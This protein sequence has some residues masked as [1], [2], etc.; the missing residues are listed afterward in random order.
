VGP[1]HFED[2]QLRI[3]R[4]VVG[5]LENNV[6]VVVCAGTGQ[7]VVIDAAAE[8]NVISAALADVEP[9]AILTTH[10]HRDHVGAAAEMRDRLG[11]PFGI[12]RAD[13]GRAGIEPDI[14]MEHGDEVAVGRLALRIIHTPGHTPG[15]VCLALPGHLFTGDTLFPGGPGATGGP[16]SSFPSIIESIRERLFPLS[17]DTVVHPGHGLDTTIG[18]ERPDL[19]EWIA[20][21]W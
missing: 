19:E 14:P 12:H 18:D 13:A 15:S 20:R 6:F 11:V 16:G 17:D 8:P 1:W 3:R 2:D 4:V 21:G 5:E 10:G 7:A 9:I